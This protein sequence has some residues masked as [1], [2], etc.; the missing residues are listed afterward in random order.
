MAKQPAGAFLHFRTTS[1]TEQAMSMQQMARS[2]MGDFM[3]FTSEAFGRYSITAKSND[4][5]GGS[6]GSKGGSGG[7]GGGSKGGSGG[8][9]GGSSGGNKGGS[10]G[11]SGGGSGGSGGGKSGSG[12]SSR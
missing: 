12:G 8:G 6:G 10:G 9:S 3:T 4:D 1:P 5:R 11:N 2:G 7:S